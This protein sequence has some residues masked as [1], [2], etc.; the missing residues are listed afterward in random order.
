MNW[1]D[2]FCLIMFYALGTWKLVDLLGAAGNW[3]ALKII[4]RLKRKHYVHYHGQC[5]TCQS[6]LKGLKDAN[7]I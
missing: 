4:K 2:I 5:E 3:T 1:F 7:K 6:I